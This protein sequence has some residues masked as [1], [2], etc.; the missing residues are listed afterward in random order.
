MLGQSVHAKCFEARIAQAGAHV[1]RGEWASGH[2]I[3]ARLLDCAQRQGCARCTDCA[4]A[5]NHLLGDI[6]RLLEH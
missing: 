4:G 3:A 2:V 5:A 1:V 6:R